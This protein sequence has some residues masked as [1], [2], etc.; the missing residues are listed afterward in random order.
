MRLAEAQNSL[1][2]TLLENKVSS[3]CHGF[4]SVSF[5]DAIRADVEIPGGCMRALSESGGPG[6]CNRLNQK[7]CFWPATFE[8]QCTPGR[9]GVPGKGCS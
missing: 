2:K 5:V 7:T 9:R 1:I 6:F 4:N 3:A 8:C